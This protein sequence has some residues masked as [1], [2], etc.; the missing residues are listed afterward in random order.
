ML[1]LTRKTGETIHIDEN[2]TIQIIQIRGPKQVRVG[3]EAPKNKKVQRGE[4]S[5]ESSIKK[6]F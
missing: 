6:V 4:L 2:I 3:I 1:V 5:S